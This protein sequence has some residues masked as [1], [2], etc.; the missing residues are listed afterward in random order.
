MSYARYS[1]IAGSGTGT[2]T[3]VGL[4]EGSS[5]PIFTITGS[6]VTGTGTLVETLKTQTANTVFSGPTTGAAAQPTFRAL[7][8][9]DFPF[10]F[11]NL[12]D[13][14]TDGIVVTGGTGAVVGSGTSIA[15]HVASGS[16]NGYLSSTDW[17]TFNNKQAALTFGNLTDVGTDGIVVTGGTGAVIGSGASLAQHVSDSTHNGYLSSTDWS[18]FNSKQAAGNYI[19][20]LTGD[21][22]AS[23]PGSVA[24]TLATV[25]SN[26]GTFGS[27]TSIPT[28]TVN[29]KGLITAASGNVVIAPAGTLTGTTLNSTVVTSSLTAVGTITTGVWTGTTIA[30]ANGGTGQTTKA[31]AFDALSP[32]TT[33]GDLLY[34]GAS[35]T[36][37]RLANGT[38]GQV[39]QSNG[40]T[41]APSWTTN[42]TGN[43]AN[44]TGTVA[45]ANG[46]TGQTTKAAGFDALSP[47]TTGGDILYGGTSGTGTRLAN[48]SSGQVLTSSGG[49]AAPTWTTA[50]ASPLFNYLANSAFDYWQRLGPAATAT[51][52]NNTRVYVVDRWYM[53]NALGTNGVLTQASTT[54][55]TN[56]SKYGCSTKITT[57]P[58][59]AQTN[60]CEFWQILENPMTLQIYNQTVVSQ[61]LVKSLNNVTQI[62]MQ[63]FFATTETAPTTGNN[64]GSEQTFTVNSSTFSTCTMTSQAMGTSA[65]TSGV[66]ALRI[67]ITAVSSGNTYDLNNGFICEQAGLWVSSAAPARWERMYNAPS[68]ELAYC[69]RFYNKT[70]PVDT[71]VGSVNA[72]PGLYHRTLDSTGGGGTVF[73]WSFPD[74]RT[75]PTTDVY[76]PGTG[77]ISKIRNTTASTDL[78]ASIS[79]AGINSATAKNDSAATVNAE[80]TADIVVSADI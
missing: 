74:M 28:F 52:S 40:T 58:T 30:L 56:G 72:N 53:R 32:L 36:G 76:S 43:A 12:T 51:A 5:T 19:T 26:V 7:V 68:A 35:G 13:A 66:I 17:T 16:F 54:G 14:G 48:G 46:G 69:K 70:L 23:G 62:G 50:V 24:A 9:A 39:L 65:T 22:T 29:G 1:G 44:V 4:S 63:Y 47:L 55:V 80:Y 42:I 45:I 8:S 15:Q 38:S 60:G 31:A 25:N 18:T 10:T 71:G 41:T 27:S 79:A 33:G 2:V 37:T 20:A 3:S 77:T 59:A 73:I 21:V 49:T 67:R 78:T 64:I 75:I 6:P 61:V 57:A 11:G 34:G